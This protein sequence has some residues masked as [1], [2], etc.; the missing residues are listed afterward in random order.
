MMPGPVAGQAGPSAACTNVAPRVLVIADPDDRGAL[1]VV[2]ALRQRADLSVELIS[3]DQLLL[4]QNWVHDPLGETEITLG[5][6][7]TLTNAT[8]GAVLCRIRHV[9][10]PQ[11]ARARRPDRIY[12]QGEFYSLIL[13]WLEQLGAKVHNRPHAGSLCGI[14]S[15]P[16]EDHLWFASRDC[17]SEPFAIATNSRHLTRKG[18]V[19]VP[20]LPCVDEAALAGRPFV[21]MPETLLAGQPAIRLADPVAQPRREITV[22]GDQ[23]FGDA[24]SPEVRTVAVSCTHERNLTL[25]SITLRDLGSGQ[26][27]FCAIDPYPALSDPAAIAAVSDLLARTA[28]EGVR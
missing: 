24:V 26:I 19:V 6:G 15:S 9:D 8:I 17:T 16:L 4:A 21:P 11:F 3:T 5:N 7:S 27:G 10:P 22:V 20:Y 12:A 23:V 18:G 14:R 2:R 1:R 13:S 25:A 28:L